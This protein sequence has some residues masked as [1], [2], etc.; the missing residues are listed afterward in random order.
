MTISITILYLIDSDHRHAIL[1]SAMVSGMSSRDIK[2]V[3][4][5]TSTNIA[6]DRSSFILI[7]HL[8]EYD[9]FD[10]SPPL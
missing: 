7:D 4:Y 1:R 9:H 5:S 6:S 2:G 10:I 3:L 8:S